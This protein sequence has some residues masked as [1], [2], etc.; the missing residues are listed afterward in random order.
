M[1]ETPQQM[2][3]R[4]WKQVFRD[5][6]PDPE[7]RLQ[8][9]KGFIICIDTDRLFDAPDRV[10]RE[11]DQEGVVALARSIK[12]RG[13]VEPIT[14]CRRPE[15]KRGRVPTYDIVHGHR[16]VAACRLL[17]QPV[18]ARIVKGDWRGLNLVLNFI[19]ADLSGIE[20]AEGIARM[21]RDME[22]T[23]AQTARA[24]G[25]DERYVERIERVA[26]LPDDTRAILAM[27]RVPV[28]SLFALVKLPEAERTRV[29][30]EIARGREFSRAELRAIGTRNQ[31]PSV[32]GVTGAPPQRQDAAIEPPA[33]AAPEQGADQPERAPPAVVRQNHVAAGR[34]E[35]KTLELKLILTRLATLRRALAA[36]DA[37][38]VR[39][40]RANETVMDLLDEIDVEVQRVQQD[41]A[42]VLAEI[43]GRRRPRLVVRNDDAS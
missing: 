27:R 39:E 41:L 31:D 10:R 36:I 15:Y 22:L 3:D 9:T 42:E 18:K 26:Q 14:V 7:Q 32:P 4:F 33:A 25:K 16:R 37:A 24:I 19:Q 28:S 21:R 1:P 29:V 2:N 12:D 30:E 35:Q 23:A 6:H 17:G 40:V 43:R 11:I 5:L 8:G 13:Q 20:I 34:A 38:V